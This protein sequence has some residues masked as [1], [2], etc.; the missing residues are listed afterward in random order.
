MTQIPERGSDL[1]SKM[2]AHSLFRGPKYSEEVIYREETSSLLFGIYFSTFDPHADTAFVICPSMLDFIVMQQAESSLGRDFATAGFPALYLHPFG[3]GYS[4]GDRECSFREHVSVAIAATDELRAR[5]GMSRI[6]FA[7]FGSGAAVALKAAMDS[8]TDPPLLLIDPALDS[9]SYLAGI[10][11]LHR[12]S[13]LTEGE[14]FE[15]LAHVLDQ[16]R[17]A[18]VLGH[19]VDQSVLDDLKQVDLLREKAVM[20]K[21]P[22][23]VGI[24]GSG[25]S[26]AYHRILGTRPV[27]VVQLSQPNGSRLG[28]PRFDRKLSQQLVAALRSML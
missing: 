23:V 26:D 18:F 6:G 8:G 9:T 21:S 17:G 24:R 15:P 22:C 27:E 13:A 7:G 19:L 14:R 28:L 12:I 10:E 5:S 16:E 11:R 4:Q 20:G 2:K 25:T 1:L 3:F